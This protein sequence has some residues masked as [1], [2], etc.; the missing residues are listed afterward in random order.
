MKYLATVE[1]EFKT[2][3]DPLEELHHIMRGKSQ[4]SWNI[5]RQRF[6]E[7]Y[8]IVAQPRELK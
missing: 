4:S 8:H 5:E 6:V 2:D 7:H 3:G 1:I